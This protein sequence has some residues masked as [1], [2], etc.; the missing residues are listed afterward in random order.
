MCRARNNSAIVD[1]F[2]GLLKSTLDCPNCGN[3][4]RKFDPFMYLSVP[5][6]GANMDFRRFTFV[7][8]GSCSLPQEFCIQLHKHDTVG[9]FL[10]TAAQ[11]IGMSDTDAFKSLTAVLQQ[12]ASLFGGSSDHSTI[13]ILEDT[14]KELPAVQGGLCVPLPSASMVA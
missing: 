2:Q 8:V 4:K 7:R 1:H 9:S 11:V 6:P 14:D 10:T 3:H 13:Q 12:P 5:L